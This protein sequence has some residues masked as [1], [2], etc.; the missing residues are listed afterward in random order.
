MDEMLVFGG[1]GSPQLTAAICREAIRRIYHNESISVLF[2][3]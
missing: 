1:S 2:P 3:Q